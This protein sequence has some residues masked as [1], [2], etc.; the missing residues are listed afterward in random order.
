MKVHRRDLYFRTK[1]QI[2]PLLKKKK[3]EKK[4]QTVVA[5]QEITLNICISGNNKTLALKLVMDYAT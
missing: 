1:N 4:G 3:K 2:R 5:N